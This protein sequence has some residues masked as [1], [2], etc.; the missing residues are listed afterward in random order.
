MAAA[1]L[2]GGR[3]PNL[4]MDGL[5]DVLLLG[6]FVGA[7]AGPML[8]FLRKG[9]KVGNPVRGITLGIVLFACSLVATSLGRGSV[10]GPH[11]LQW[12]TA[13]VAAAVFAAYGI[14]LDAMMNH[15][16]GG[17]SEEPC[18]KQDG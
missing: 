12:S 18:R 9:L 7:V 11:G 15:I 16:D 3:D 2:M 17:T 14:I 13:A 6:T 8:V 5:I 10:V 4:S 1:A